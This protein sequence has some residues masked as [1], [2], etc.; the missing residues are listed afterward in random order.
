[1]LGTSGYRVYM[2]M[3]KGLRG[4][5]ITRHLYHTAADKR[6][7]SSP[8]RRLERKKRQI[9]RKSFKERESVDAK[10]EKSVSSEFVSLT[11]VVSILMQ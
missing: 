11:C 10:T 9:N 6:H 5:M 4:C 8:K 2:N 1:M 7:Y 3:G